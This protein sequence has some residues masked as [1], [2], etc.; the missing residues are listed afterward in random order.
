MNYNQLSELVCSR[1][2]DLVDQLV[3]LQENGDEVNMAIV[4]NEIRELTAAMDSEDA[5]DNFFFATDY[6]H[7]V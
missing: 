5:S 2:N 4:N 1:I 6:K 7:L 3:R